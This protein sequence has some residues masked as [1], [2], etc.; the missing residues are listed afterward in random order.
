LTAV[1][2][3]SFENEAKNWFMKT[4]R[5]LQFIS[6]AGFYGAEMWI[7]ALAKSLDPSQVYCSL[8]VT[9]ES[10]EQ[11]LTLF[12]R[13]L[14]LKLGAHRIRMNGRFDFRSIAKLWALMK[15][16][17][18]DILHTHGYKSDLLGLVSARM[19]GVKT[20]A[21]PHGFDNARDI[22]LRAFIRLGCM[23]LRHF[24]RVVPLSEELMAD[25]QRIK[26]PAYKTRLIR[27]GVDLQEVLSE[28][29][30][31]TEPVFISNGEK[32]I[33]YVGQVAYRKNLGAMID[34]FDL[35][36]H[37]HKNIRLLIIGEGRMRD[38]LQSKAKMLAS[39]DRIE[40]LGYRSDRL[41]FVKELDLFCMTSSLE[42]IPRC[43]MEAMAMGVPVAAF[44]IPGVDKLIMHEK[45]GLLAP[46]GDIAALKKCWERILF[47]DEFAKKL[48]ENGKK[49]I[50]DNF[51]AKR[52]ADE[53]TALYQEMI[54]NRP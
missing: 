48:A 33:G 18:F 27:N 1:W 14:K 42:G 17:Q 43:M 15:D 7:L 38:A 49:H 52:M 46:Y 39:A 28:N 29:R 5:V 41:R 35:F 2:A 23:A 22:K 34:A 26:V 30:R 10:V 32:R 40:F 24:D 25:M 20:V 54:M 50:Q 37:D 19:A 8:A 9:E 36:Y 3:A 11:D 6:P 53:Y 12:D 51:S 16:G 45:T 21:T 13:Y 4:V 44:D 31:V 47:N